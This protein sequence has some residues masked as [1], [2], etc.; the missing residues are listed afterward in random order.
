MSKPI[1]PFN[2]PPSGDSN[3]FEKK[4]L[5]DINLSFGV[6]QLIG[7]GRLALG[8]FMQ[9][10]DHVDHGTRHQPTF[11]ELEGPRGTEI[12]DMNQSG[13]VVAAPGEKQRIATFGLCGCTAV[14]VVATFPD[15]TRRA[16]VQ[17]YDS[18]RKRMDGQ[19]HG[20]EEMILSR[21][22]EEGAYGTASKVDA[23]IMIPGGGIKMAPDDPA[24]AEWL[25]G[26][27]KKDF[28]ETTTVT[29]SPYSK[30]GQDGQ[31]HYVTALVIDIPVQGAPNIF[32]GMARISTEQ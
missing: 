19:R 8:S 18:F 3:G 4:P 21:E 1:K 12:I 9:N 16:H 26:T 23:V 30:S 10:I 6:D 20:L 13:H 31:S 22:A 14:G 24:H 2:L 32:P 11:L 27:L 29:V 5:T 7:T 15:G 28:G 17:H 25:T